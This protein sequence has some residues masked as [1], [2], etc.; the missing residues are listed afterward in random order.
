[1]DWTQFF[2]MLGVTI[3]GSGGVSGVIIHLWKSSINAKYAKELAEYEARIDAKYA[4]E[5][6]GYKAGYQRFLDENNIRF[7]WWHQ[8]KAMAIKEVFAA[9]SRL[10][11]SL[12]HMTAPV[13]YVPPDEEEKKKYL[14]GLME[15]VQKDYNSA[16][17]SWFLRRIFFIN[18]NNDLN[19]DIDKIL[20]NCRMAISYYRR[21]LQ[22]KD[23]FEIYDKMEDETKAFVET[24]N[25]LQTLFVATLKNNETSTGDKQWTL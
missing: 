13:Q 23:S 9:L 2:S 21:T 7:S 8:E 1:M 25:K 15:A 14:Q 22:K 12:E 19:D 3:L 11:L 6:E 24:L 16:L 18:T 17:E 10:Q 20:R 4:K 5:L